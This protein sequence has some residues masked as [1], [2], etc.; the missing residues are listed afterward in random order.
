MS[1]RLSPT[2]EV[3][4]SIHRTHLVMWMSPDILLH[5]M[6]LLT[7]GPLFQTSP[8]AH[9]FTSYLCNLLTPLPHQTIQTSHHHHLSDT[10]VLIN[11]SM[12]PLTTY[13][14][15]PSLQTLLPHTPLNQQIIPKQPNTH[16][17]NL[18]CKMSM[19]LLFA[20]TLGLLFPLH[21]P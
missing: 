11:L 12:D 19:M 4:S 13:Y 10:K 17:G 16:N 2:I 14:L 6:D 15:M 9:H 1:P 5:L 7:F 20:T 3:L 18:S 8:L 21:N